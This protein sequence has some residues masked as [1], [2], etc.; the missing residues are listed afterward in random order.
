VILVLVLAGG[1][2]YGLSYYFKSAT[3]TITPKNVSGAT[4]LTL[5]LSENG[6][7]GIA[8]QLVTLPESHTKDIT[9]THTDVVATKAKGTV[10]LYNSQTTS[11]SLVATTRF[12]DTSGTLFR[13]QNTV[14]IPKQTVSGGVTTPGQVTVTLVADQAGTT[15]NIGL[16]DFAVVAFKGTAK[17]KQVY[18]RGK[19]AFTGGASGPAYFLTDDEYTT[20]VTPLATGLEDTLKAD[21]LKQVPDGYVLLPNSLAYLPDPIANPGPSTTATI[22]VSAGAKMRGILIKKSDLSELILNNIAP[23]ESATAGDIS[24]PKLDALTYTSS[25]NLTQAILPE[26]IPLSIEGDAKV[27]W[28]V[29]QAA[30]KENLKGVSRRDFAAKMQGFS[31][32]KEAALT[33][34]PFWMSKL[35][36]DVHKITVKIA[37]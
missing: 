31:S 13:L 2:V 9:A 21:I 25:T 27:V 7:N 23:Q 8:Y 11:Q 10:V 22:T 20:A 32:V 1:I 24:V 3:V 17:E 33:L 5:T 15:G 36:T 28:N 37:E 16:S 14:T 19:T 30:V 4:S 12:T 29:D 6:S 34:T 35:P 26:T 18:G